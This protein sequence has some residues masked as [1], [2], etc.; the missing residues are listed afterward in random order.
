[1]SNPF[2]QK[3]PHLPITNNNKNSCHC[4][5]S[6]H[7]THT[8]LG[9]KVITGKNELVKIYNQVKYLPWLPNGFNSHPND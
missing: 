4:V 5:S 8:P 3:I 6:A 9:P 1:M 7:S 2:F